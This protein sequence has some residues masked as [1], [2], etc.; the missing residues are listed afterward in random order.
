WVDAEVLRRI[1]R[2]SL[3]ASRR[4]IAPVTGPVY[5][6]FLGQW[7]HLVG[8]R[9]DGGRERGTW[10][11]HD[12][13]LSVIDQLAGV[14]LPLSAWETQVLPARLPEMTPALL[15]A[16]F[17]S[18]E[19]VW[20]GHGRLSADDGWIRL[21]LAD[22]LPLGLDAEALE[23]AAADLAAGSLAARILE[24]L[25]STPGALR[26]GEILAA[27]ADAGEAARPQ[28]LPQALWAPAFPG[29]VLH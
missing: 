21:H 8:R 7:Q 16:A 5:A 6:R 18:G 14:S 15:D 27:L 25:R 9:E 22:A 19:L 3:A 24:L 13:L 12:G 10:T 29:R 23:E 11:G 1:R 26:H 17:A 4:E 20:T 2:A 28:A